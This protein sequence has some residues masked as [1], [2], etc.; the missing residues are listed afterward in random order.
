MFRFCSLVVL[1]LLQYPVFAQ[2]NSVKQMVQDIRSADIVLE[3]EVTRVEVFQDGTYVSDEKISFRA[4]N[5]AGR[6]SLGI[7]DI[8]FSPDLTDVKVVEAYSK[9]AGRI[10]KVNL[11][12][13]QVR[14]L[15]PGNLGMQNYKKYLIPYDNV[16]VGSRAY[17]HV[18]RRTKKSLVSGAAYMGYRYGLNV[19]ELSSD[20]EIVS[21][22]P[23]YVMLIDK[24]GDLVVRQSKRGSKH[25]VSIRTKHPIYKR[26]IIKKKSLM[27]TGDVPIVYVSTTKNWK[28]IIA[29]VNPKYQQAINSPLP[30]QFQQIVQ[31]ANK[32]KD[33][34]QKMNYV[35]AQV[36]K[37]IAYSGDWTDMNRMYFPRGHNQVVKSA[38][39]D[40]K[41][42]ATSIAGILRKLGY[43]ANVALV[44]SSS[45]KVRF[46][47]DVGLDKL[48]P[49][50]N[51]F[52]HAIT[53]VKLKSGKSL[54]LDGTRVAVDAEEIWPNIASSP[55]LILSKN[56][57]GISR[58]P[59]VGKGVSQY[60]LLRT[61]EPASSKKGVWKGQVYIKGYDMVQLKEMQKLYGIHE[62]NK[63]FPTLLLWGLESQDSKFILPKNVF[64]TSLNYA[65]FP[66]NIVGLNPFS[67]NAN[68]DNFLYLSAN[69][70]LLKYFEASKETGVYFGPP[71][72][73][74]VQTTYKGVT[75][76]DPI[77]GECFVL[78][79][80]MTYERKVTTINKDTIVSEKIKTHKTLITKD[81]AKGDAYSY[82]QSNLA[83][84][85]RSSKLTAG[86]LSRA[87][88]LISQL[89]DIKK[90]PI[91]KESFEQMVVY[92]KEAKPQLYTYSNLKMKRI[93]E[94]A[95]KANK[96]NYEARVHRAKAIL[97]LGYLVGTKHTPEFKYFAHHELNKILMEA[98]GFGKALAVRSKIFQLDNKYDHA[99][100]DMTAAYKTD[101]E[102]P[103]YMNQIGVIY[104]DKGNKK[105]ANTWL[106]AGKS[107]ATTKKQLR[108]YWDSLA[109][110]AWRFKDWKKYVE[111]RKALVEM[112]PDSAW[113]YHNLSIAYEMNGN[114]EDGIVSSKKAIAMMD[115]GA[116][117]NQ[118]ANVLR[119][120]AATL[121]EE[122]N[123][124]KV[125]TN[126]NLEKIL[127]EAYKFDE[128][129]EWTYQQLVFIY[130]NRTIAEQES[131]WLDSADI[132][133]TEGLK[134]F[135]SSQALRNY[136]K[137]TWQ[138]KQRLM[139]MF[140]R[141]GIKPSGRWP[142]SFQNR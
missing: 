124:E 17:Y 39:G 127:L 87:K 21:A 76:I 22:L 132:Y 80:W 11:K 81:E 48:V 107:R 28:E 99:L 138:L 112:N 79:P 137:Q 110:V 92:W 52:N 91:A 83:S 5:E 64:N 139:T 128:N 108:N 30:K 26:H 4:Q 119:K 2:S 72:N 59:E 109:D 77:D 129:D 69:P 142:A 117:R 78:S 61:F 115:F 62:L 114:F 89:P 106:A 49:M 12:K 16:K 34:V 27:T 122:S 70:S 101:P 45:P 134:K 42:F 118:L 35:T 82:F 116:G 32:L 60:R 33:D 36:S 47:K 13:I 95:I 126:K 85:L 123:T 125:V 121:L 31:S 141:Q 25:V 40:C 18:K 68:G 56:S 105:L 41:D 29:K 51:Y 133:L 23:L 14:S 6:T 7:R 63:Q 71:T 74:E 67:D 9:T 98:P 100:A 90:L 84:C 93:A 1:L 96:K 136:E 86:N 111:A 75:V 15:S 37:L 54:W 113:A 43:D 55:A 66:F 104:G 97:Q 44:L 140:R 3:K 103:I 20:V 58:V 24:Y 135:P 65:K 10:S 102:N 131:D 53:H 38:K 50:P 94:E 19:P 8:A 88:Q 120:K 130:V 46:Y 57:Q 73:V